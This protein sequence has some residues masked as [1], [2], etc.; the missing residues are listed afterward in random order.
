MEKNE[1][2]LHEVVGEHERQEYGDP[3][4]VKWQFV[5]ELKQRGLNLWRRQ[6]SGLRCKLN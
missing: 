1:N 6:Q 4:K 5:E 3:G 2:S